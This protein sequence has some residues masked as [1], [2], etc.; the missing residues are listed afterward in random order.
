MN[1]RGFKKQL[2][3][4]DLAWRSAAVACHTPAVRGRNDVAKMTTD[5]RGDT[6]NAASLEMSILRSRAVIF[7]GCLNHM[8]GH[9][10]SGTDGWRD[11]APSGAREASLTSV[12][13]AR[14]RA[15]GRSIEFRHS[16]TAFQRGRLM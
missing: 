6:G 9:S 14:S 10:S 11:R 15:A 7:Y 12:N 4:I 13:P 5:F 1:N 3:T 16:P 2:Q 8:A